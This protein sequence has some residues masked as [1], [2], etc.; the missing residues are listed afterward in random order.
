MRWRGTI[1]AFVPILL[2]AILVQPIIAEPK[3]TEKPLKVKLMTIGQENCLGDP[4]WSAAS[5]VHLKLRLEIINLTNRRLIVSRAIGVVWYDFIVAKDRQT[6]AAGIY[7]YKPIIDWMTDIQSPQIEAPSAE[8]TILSRG[9][10]FNVEST[11]YLI[12]PLESGSHVLQLTL[13]TWF[14]VQ[15][16]ESFRKSWKKYGDLVYDPVRSDSLSFLVPAETDF[17]RCKF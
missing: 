7:E 9:K 12:E 15:R 10:S 11:V 13:G 5:A 16:P 2:F 1:H 8:F 6:L 3:N 14:H 17:V 4:S